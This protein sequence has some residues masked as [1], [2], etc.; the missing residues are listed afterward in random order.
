ML[1]RTK[2]EGYARSGIRLYF[3]DLGGSAPDN[4][5]MNAAA[6]SQ[7]ALS[8][9]QLD[10]AKDVYAST[11]P[12]RAAATQRANAVSDAQLAQMKQQTT[13][14]QDYADYNKG[15]FR[16]LEQ[17]IVKEA[18]NY[19]TQDRRDAEA[20]KAIGDVTQGFSAAR[21]QSVRAQERMGVNP[22]SGRATA[23]QN[24]VDIAQA[25]ATAGA[26]AKARTQVET[27]GFARKMDAASLGRNLPSAQAT[28]ASLASQFGAGSVASSAAGITAA[29]SGNGVMQTGFNGASNSMASAGSIYGNMA[30]IQ[31][32]SNASSNAGLGV[33]GSVAGQFAGS[34]AGSAA[35]VA[36]SD[37]NV[38]ED[39]QP[40]SDDEALEQ[41]AGTPVAT[42]AY[43]KGSAGDDGGQQHTG[44]MAQDVKKNMGDQVA[45]GGKQI[46]LISL[47]GKNMAA[48]GAL[49]RNVDSLNTKVSSI[50]AMMGANLNQQRSQPVAA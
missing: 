22:N 34:Q 4:S 48:I 23:M 11:A 33:L 36:L 3:L 6:V 29:N 8:K 44:P 32:Q 50:A 39:I 45:P 10:W 49:K 15:T 41:V 2:F 12:D 18:N 38:K 42:W 20:G 5:G 26:A 24:G 35:L 14:A 1:I 9:E 46:D 25:T 40:V 13:I 28:S 17:G 43:K 31:Q 19:D 37:K 16:P 21:E 30:Q 47:N 27:T 7:A